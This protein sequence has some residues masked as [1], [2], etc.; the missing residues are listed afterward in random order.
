MSVP[1]LVTVWSP[2]WPM[3]AARIPPGRPAAV[4]HANRVVACTPEARAAG[5]AVG[6][7]R[8]VAQGACPELEV[9]ER[10]IDRDGREFDAVVRIVAEL[11]PRLEVVQP[12]W[13]S[14]AARGPARYYGGDHAVAE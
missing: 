10:D 5:V 4:F 14:L 7:R 6:D 11:A 3:V 1:R 8:R 12:G 2:D 13:L 9:L